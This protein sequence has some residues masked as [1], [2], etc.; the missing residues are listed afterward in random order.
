MSD[1]KP[2]FDFEHNGYRF[3]AGDDPKAK[4]GDARVRIF[5]GT[6]VV[7]DFGWPAY[8]VWN[9]Q[10]HADDIVEG[11]KG[12]RDDG[13]RLAGSTGLGGGVYNRRTLTER[14]FET[15]ASLESATAHLADGTMVAG[16]MAINHTPEGSVIIKMSHTAR[17]EVAT[18]LRDAATDIQNRNVTPRHECDAEQRVN[19]FAA[20]IVEAAKKRGGF[21]QGVEVDSA[22]FL[23][24]HL[25]YTERKLEDAR[26][27]V[28]DQDVVIAGL[29]RAFDE[30]MAGVFDVEAL[31]ARLGT[32]VK[33]AKPA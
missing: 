14:L 7:R 2:I 9:I 10:A 30:K 22:T 33:D 25:E 26:K 21:D 3:L 11:L 18:L 8:K 12:D 29:C 6:E 17:M 27:H 19:D 15:A 16:G 23:V 32:L 31:L 4:K 1:T 5:K 24:Q 20:T 28:K 13:L